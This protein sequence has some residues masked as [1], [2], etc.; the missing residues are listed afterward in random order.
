MGLF[1]RKKNKKQEEIKID[2][3]QENDSVVEENNIENNQSDNNAQL[4]NKTD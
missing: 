3:Y 1:K 4:N 2:L